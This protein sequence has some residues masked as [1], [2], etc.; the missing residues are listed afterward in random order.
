MSRYDWWVTLARVEELGG[1]LRSFISM[2]DDL[3][4]GRE[5]RDN[6]ADL[7]TGLLAAVLRENGWQLGHAGSGWVRRWRLGWRVLA[8]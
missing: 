6:F 7:I 1:D 2:T 4:A 5:A 8:A 3:F